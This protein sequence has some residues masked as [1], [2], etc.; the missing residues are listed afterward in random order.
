MQTENEPERK[1]KNGH[2]QAGHAMEMLG[3]HAEEWRKRMST[4]DTQLRTV[5]RERPVAVVCGALVLGYII[6]RVVR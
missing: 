3:E 4:I 2:D 6:G 5:A 1:K